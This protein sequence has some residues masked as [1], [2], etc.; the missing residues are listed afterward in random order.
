MSVESEE[1][2]QRSP[3]LAESL[4]YQLRTGSKSTSG[5]SLERDEFAGR[6]CAALPT[7]V[8]NDE[9]PCLLLT[10]NAAL[11]VLLR[12]GLGPGS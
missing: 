4:I 6:R 12:P 10:G 11:V 9:D 1:V 2:T 3:T 7:L 5:T 8:Q